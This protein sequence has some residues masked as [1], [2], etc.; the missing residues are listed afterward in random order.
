MGRRL[1]T[2]SGR[3]GPTFN[4]ACLTRSP[5]FNGKTLERLTCDK[6]SL[7]LRQF[8]VP[9]LRCSCRPLNLTILTG[10]IGL[11]MACS[12][13]DALPADPPPPPNPTPQVDPSLLLEYY[14]G[15]EDGSLTYVYFDLKFET[16][17]D[18]LVGLWRLDY[19]ATVP[20]SGG[21]AV[22]RVE[23]DSIS[24]QLHSHVGACSGSPRVEGRVSQDGD[25]LFVRVQSDGDCRGTEGLIV[26]TPCDDRDDCVR[27]DT[28]PGVCFAWP[29][30]SS[31]RRRSNQPLELRAR[32]AGDR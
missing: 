18:S 17:S 13:S 31:T 28:G 25:T 16:V 22:A 27:C 21:V 11:G 4:S 8:V 24:I 19:S 2:S 14:Y 26:M 30:L 29:S 15:V 3:V 6:V 5:Q 23:G 7:M 20:P 10:V 9:I 1:R 32:W 12:G